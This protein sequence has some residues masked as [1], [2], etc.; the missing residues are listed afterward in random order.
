[1]EKVK[2]APGLIVGK[3]TV[4]EATG[5]RKNG[6]TVWRCSCTCGGERLLDT[7]TLQRGSI[8]DCGCETLVAPGQ[9]DLTG[10]RFGKLTCLEP[11]QE[12]SQSG[13]LIWRCHCDCGTDCLAESTQLISGRK[14]SCGC[15]SYPALKNYIGAQFGQLTVITYEGKRSGM[16]RWRCR[17]SCGNET[18]VGQTL[19]QSGKTKSCGCLQAGM[20]KKNMK[21]VEGTSVARLEKTEK[22]LI[23]TN[24]SGYNGVYFNK[25]ANR[26]IAQIGFKGKNY[27]LGSYKKIDDAVMARKKAESRIYGEFLER[28][29]EICQQAEPS[30]K[31]SSK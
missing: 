10:L 30:D 17:C 14:K 12:R 11:I 18:V 9:R 26:W 20:A 24:T 27:H 21:Y 23:R 7:R 31:Q 3:L 16:H 22:R 4:M 2:I 6:Y 8:R 15:L 25:K 5:Q 28:Y 29:Y 1:M 13:G 19:L